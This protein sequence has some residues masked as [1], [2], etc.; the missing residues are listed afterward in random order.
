MSVP[1]Y[2]GDVVPLKFTIT[3]A[4]GAVNPSKVVVLI[5][6]PGN[7]VSN[8]VEAA[9]D[10]NAVSYTVPATITQIAGHYKAYF[11]CTLASGERTH[12]MEFKITKNPER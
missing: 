6:M 2:S 4:D 12:R 10:G 1:Y 9:I 5:L 3:D 7:E 8:G 11:V